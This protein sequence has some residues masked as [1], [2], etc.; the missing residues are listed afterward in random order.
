MAAKRP[1]VIHPDLPRC[2]FMMCE[3][4]GL[5]RIRTKLGWT[6]YCRRHCDEYHLRLA[7]ETCH[8]LGLDTVEAKREYVREKMKAIAA[9]WRMPG[10]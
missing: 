6:N 5:I 3:M 4:P 10:E 7:E 2:A 1:A 8:T 9:K